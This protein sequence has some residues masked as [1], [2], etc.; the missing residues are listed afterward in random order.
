MKKDKKGRIKEFSEEDLVTHPEEIMTGHSVCN[1]CGKDM[2]ICWDTVCS[3]CLKTF[4]YDCS[5]ASLLKWYCLN[6][7]PWWN[8][9]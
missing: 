3:V 2:P 7:N 1:K 4:C 8:L 6:C 9:I 5:K